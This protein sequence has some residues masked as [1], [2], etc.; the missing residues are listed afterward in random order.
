MPKYHIYPISSD[1][2]FKT[3]PIIID[4]NADADAMVQAKAL[5]ATYIGAE[6]WRGNS[7]IG[8]VSS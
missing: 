7:L 2:L 8:R 3:T 5:A 4:V 1:N 6:V